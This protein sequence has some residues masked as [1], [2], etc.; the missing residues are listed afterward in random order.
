MYHVIY[1]IDPIASTYIRCPLVSLYIV[2]YFLLTSAV[3]LLVQR[4]A[5][6]CEYCRECELAP[7][8]NH[9]SFSNCDRLSTRKK[10]V[11]FNDPCITVTY[12]STYTICRPLVTTPHSRVFSST[13]SPTMYY[14]R[15]QKCRPERN[16]RKQKKPQASTYR[17]VFAEEKPFH[18]YSH[19]IVSYGMRMETPA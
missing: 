10:T 8:P 4:Y 19:L 11:H 15:D 2:C 12:H 13:L 6:A 18:R 9:L 3:V 17:N 14:F 5:C 1:R 16:P 7:T